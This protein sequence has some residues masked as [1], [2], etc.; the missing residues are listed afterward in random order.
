MKHYL[1][2]SAPRT[3]KD[4]TPSYI[5]EIELREYY[6]PQFRE[7]VKA[8]ASTIMINSG[9]INGTPVHASKYL[10]NDV[11]RKELGFKGLIVSDW[12]DVIRLHTRHDVAASPRAAVALAVNS[13]IDM[14]MVPT[15]FSFYD[16]L[17]KRTER[18]GSGEQD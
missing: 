12:E 5:P 18:R 14:S 8:G 17:K 16:L 7:A 13:G 9:D 2:Y 10:L 4:R 3:G 1:A 11:L 6:L 15:N